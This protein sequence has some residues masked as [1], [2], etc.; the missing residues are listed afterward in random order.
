MGIQDWSAYCAAGTM[1][2]YT[3]GIDWAGNGTYSFA[4]GAIVAGSPS[5]S[6]QTDLI[7]T[8][9]TVFSS[10]G[11]DQS[12]QFSPAKMGTAS[13]SLNNTKRTYSPENVNSP[14]W[15]N[16]DA[17]RGMKGTVFFNGTNYGLFHG[18]IND[19]NVHADRDDRTSSFT[20]YDDQFLFQN[21]K[22]STALYSGVR[23]GTA[24]QTLLTAVG[25]QGPVD[26]D[27]G[28]SI[29]PFWWLNQTPASQAISDLVKSEGPPAIAYVDPFGTFVFR[30]RHHRMLRTQSTTSQATFGEPRMFDC[31]APAVTG[32]PFTKPFTYNHGS[33]DI[34]NSAQ[35]SV[36]QRAQQ[37]ALSTVWSTTNIYSVPNGTTTTITV[38]GND[39][40]T[41]AVA[42][43][44]VTDYAVTGAGTLTVTLDKTSGQT[45]TLTLSSAGGDCTVNGIQ[46]RA[47]SVPVINTVVVQWQDTD[48]IKSHGQQD[49]PDTA[50]WASQYDAQAIAQAIV[51]RYAQKR[52]TILMRTIPSQNPTAFAQI[53]GRAVSDRITVN[54]AEIGLAADF[55]IEHI[56]HT[57]ARMNQKGLP[58]VHAVVLGCEKETTVTA[59]SFQFDTS[60]HGFD[61]G[62][63]QPPVADSA[64]TVFVFDSATNGLFDTNL[65]AT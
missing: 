51:L 6:V 44:A 18:V 49:Y 55:F 46:L 4:P 32:L 25:W 31:A 45:V 47:Y 12:R 14:L 42:P 20:F 11:R 34:V 36:S 27:P 40:F 37:P 2:L 10:F 59:V 17:S 3:W 1:P 38:S 41:G 29:L 16:L 52:P 64:A 28:D 61:Q 39:P 43:V 33:R 63:F 7:G 26:L 56:E 35:F 9:G 24:M 50:P 23:T 8:S 19:Y 58:P 57:I 60:G 30:S 15:S 21:T 54:N 53:L 62:A 13:F 65:F 22:V 5:S 48:S